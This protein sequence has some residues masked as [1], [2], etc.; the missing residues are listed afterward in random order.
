MT[1]LWEK[2]TR[3]ML[4]WSE[5]ELDSFLHIIQKVSDNITSHP[6]D[7]KYQKLKFNNRL[8]N[9]KINAR[10]GGVDFMLAMGFDVIEEEVTGAARGTG[11]EK[12]Y[13][14]RKDGLGSIA[15]S[16]SWLR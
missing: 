15:A 6:E 11:S 2:C 10:T 3:H 8:V 12:M 9:E 13:V 5:D 7:T 14:L 16:V 1:D 4:L